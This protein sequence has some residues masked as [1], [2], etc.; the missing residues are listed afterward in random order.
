M[1][2]SARPLIA[3]DTCILARWVMRDDK[4]QAEAADT[5]LARPFFIGQTVLLE[6][7]WLLR[8]A[9]RMDRAQL[10][11][12]LQT[13]TGLPTAV[14]ENADRVRWAIERYAQRGDLADLLHV[15]NAVGVRSIA[16]FDRKF[17]RDATPNAPT[18][19]ELAGA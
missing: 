7:G 4:A 9:G 11:E 19:V 16:T 14:V 15:A 13:L 6:L 1:G 3:L 2:K 5:L 10:A 17:V 18:Q 12:T 8:T